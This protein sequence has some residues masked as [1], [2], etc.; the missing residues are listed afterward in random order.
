M[1]RLSG[2]KKYE[3]FEFNKEDDRVEVL[4]KKLLGK[5]ANQ[6]KKERR[7]STVD[8]Y[9]FL[10]CC[11][12]LFLISF[13]FAFLS[14][15]FYIRSSF[16]WIILGLLAC[17]KMWQNL[18]LN[19]EFYDRLGFETVRKYKLEFSFVFY[20]CIFSG[21]FSFMLTLN[22][23][24]SLFGVEM[25]GIWFLN[26]KCWSTWGMFGLIDGK[27]NRKCR[28]VVRL[29]LNFEALD[30]WSNGSWESEL[31]K[32]RQQYVPNTTYC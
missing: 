24:F 3:V 13:Y 29:V 27:M 6:R 4:S 21:F 16:G 5:F 1:S 12:Y 30:A 25:E 2:K 23:W 26:F 10:Q 14:L 31:T 18:N 15:I 11:E 17:E 32:K 8:K 9:T 19:F 20:G 28:K 7:S 22:W